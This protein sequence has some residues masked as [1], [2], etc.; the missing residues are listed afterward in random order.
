MNRLFSKGFKPLSFCAL[1]ITPFCSL[2]S[3]N[4]TWEGTISNDVTV[5]G[6]WNPVGPPTNTDAGQFSSLATSLTPSLQG[7]L[8][9]QIGTIEF[10]DNT[11]FN[12]LVDNTFI[13]Q[14]QG[15]GVQNFG[16]TS[17]IFNISNGGSLLFQNAAAADNGSTL[18]TYNVGAT[19]SLS[20]FNTA[21]ANFAN[22]SST[23]GSINFLDNSNA[24]SSN[25]ELSGTSALLSFFNNSLA[26]FTTITAT[27]QSSVDFRSSAAANAANIIAESGSII[28]FYNTT[29]GNSCNISLNN[30]TLSLNDSFNAL[31]TDITGISSNITF[32]DTS[33][34]AASH[35]GLTD[36]VINYTDGSSAQ[37]STTTL[38][39]SQLNFFDN[40]G[41]SLS[42]TT[43]SAGSTITF[44]NAS[45]A[46][47]ATINTTG[48]SVQFEDT[49]TAS[50][51]VFHAT[52]S[53]ILFIDNSLSASASVTLNANSTLNFLQVA[54]DTFTGTLLGNGITNKNGTG[55]LNF[56]ANGG[57]YTGQTQI[58][59]GIFALNSSLGG[60]IF[61]DTSG[62]LSGIGN[63][64]GNVT[65][66]NGGIISPGNSIGTLSVSGNYTQNP[67]SFYLVELNG[68]GQS[69]LIDIAGTSTI[70]GGTV[71]AISTDGTFTPF[72]PYTILHAD[73]GVTGAY[74]S[75]AFLTNPAF[76]VNLVY[77]PTNVF[78]V[79]GTNFQFLAETPNQINV[80]A[81][82]DSLLNPTGDE[83][84][85]IDNLL[86]LSVP[87]LRNALDQMGGEQYTALVQT[88]HQSTQ[89]FLR[90]IYDPIRNI[91]ADP[92]C[93]DPCLNETS[94][95][96]A[97][98][99]GHSNMSRDYNAHSYHVNNY[100]ISL[101]AQK[102]FNEEFT[103]GAAASYDENKIHY[104]LGG[105]GKLHYGM[106]GVYAA[107][108]NACYYVLS[109]LV[110]GYNDCKVNRHI[111][112]ADIDRT[113]SS[114][115]TIFQTTF[116][117]EIGKNFDL[118]NFAVQPFIGVEVGYYNRHRI[119]ENGADSLNLNVKRRDLN[120][121]T[122][123]LG[124]HT[125][126]FV[127][128][129][130]E[131]AAD[132]AWQHNFNFTRDRL[133]PS[134]QDF[135]SD[136]QII[137]VNIQ[138]DSLDVA[139]LCSTCISECF[140]VYA[141]VSGQVWNRY[142]NISFTGGLQYNW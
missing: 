44:N 141:E 7:G 88:T 57:A 98:E 2:Y 62:I 95:W 132:V 104:S 16:S 6:N 92:C 40:A 65:I 131:F 53:A 138:R 111:E 58:S 86:T 78:L 119:H 126:T 5:G 23:N 39:N 20:F 14:I 99:G 112:F 19:S 74:T 33:Q 71:N 18:I 124:V 75:G 79:L 73:G 101:G 61:V 120:I 94:V 91:L 84:V 41:A 116:Y 30:A 47:S 97:G 105:S 123:R 12:F 32:A 134:F 70:N 59:N 115:P 90:R 10:L 67:G 24:G 63:A 108:T 36:S 31:T 142:S 13:F 80:A 85:V 38:V 93:Y 87:E 4:F 103:F 54:N 51:A 81:Q 69:D 64:L 76:R 100:S 117:T 1:L 113:A 21:N 34:A 140:D 43:A 77:D 9:Y 137:G 55:V 106:G 17:Q 11:A 122:S 28:S 125:Q 135:G 56:L 118:C 96:V 37:G 45:N 66:N 46:Q 26:S 128:C 110:V 102:R 109:D 35:I 15:T 127:G 72:L 136:F 49:A 133:T 107:Y 130:F 48:S 50:S 27:N 42:T 8:A 52:D 129:G 83:V 68:A 22:F 89:R 60:N 82:F 121:T 3:A 114:K 29:T 139:L 25:I